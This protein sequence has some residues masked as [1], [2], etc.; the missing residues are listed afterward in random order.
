MSTTGTDGNAIT[1]TPYADNGIN[2]Q[3]FPQLS[4]S[5]IDS[6]RFTITIG[7]KLILKKLLRELKD[8]CT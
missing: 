8:K 4:D 5:D 2:A 6:E 3:A 1:Q 7:G